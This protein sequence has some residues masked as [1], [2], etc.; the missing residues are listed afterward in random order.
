MPSPRVML[1]YLGEG[2]ARRS[3]CPT[4][5]RSAHVCELTSE[6]GWINSRRTIARVEPL[7]ATVSTSLP[8][9]GKT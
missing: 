3:P 4:P 6:E 8:V 9:G 7:Q 5:R 1:D 2:P